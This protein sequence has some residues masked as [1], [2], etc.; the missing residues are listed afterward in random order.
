ME[1]YRIPSAKGIH[2]EYF[3]VFFSK[4]QQFMKPVGGV[5]GQ[6]GECVF[7]PKLRVNAVEFAGG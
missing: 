6:L 4:R 5:I 7:E 3:S 1:A 2:P